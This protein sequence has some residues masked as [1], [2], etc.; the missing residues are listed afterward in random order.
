MEWL[1]FALKEPSKVKKICK[2]MKHQDYSSEFFCLRNFNRYGR[3][4]SI[5]SMLP[6]NPKLTPQN[7]YGPQKVHIPKQVVQLPM[8]PKLTE[9]GTYKQLKYFE[10]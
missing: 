8:N 2:K 9:R 6:M 4:I 1:R 10:V 7:R 5:V 3:Y